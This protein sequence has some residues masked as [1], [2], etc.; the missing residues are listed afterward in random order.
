MK[1][2][3]L[4]TADANLKEFSSIAKK[5]AEGGHLALYLDHHQLGVA[6]SEVCENYLGVLLCVT[7]ESME[8]GSVLLGYETC[9]DK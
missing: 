5:L 1:R 7:N 8:C 9:N 3:I 2:K 4:E 6:S